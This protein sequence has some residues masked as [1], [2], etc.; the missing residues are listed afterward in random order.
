MYLNYPTKSYLDIATDIMAKFNI[1]FILYKKTDF[2]NLV[3]RIKKIKNLNIIK[4]KIL[5]IYNQSD[6]NYYQSVFYQ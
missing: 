4:N 6:K 1:K 5:I 2:N 3:E